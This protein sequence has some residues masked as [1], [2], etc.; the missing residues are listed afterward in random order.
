MIALAETVAPGSDG[1][2]F[3]PHPRGRICP[4]S[5][6]MRGAWVG[7]SWSHTQ[8]HF[9]RA[10]LE[11]IAY[12]YAYYLRILKE[13][14]PR[15]TLTEARVVGGGARSAV[16]NQLK[17]DI[18]DVQYQRLKGNEFGTWGAAMIAGKAAGVIDDLA[19]HA[20]EAAHR[21]GEAFL[22]SPEAHTTYLPHIEKYVALEE[23]MQH[24]FA[25]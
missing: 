8:A 7:A 20:E 14:L 10:I 5:P 3:S 19:V 11:S 21:D 17:A 12:E 1:L 9:T 4:S 25:G 22:P 2:Y 16:W 18:L 24:F 13:L 15:F 6:D 23:V